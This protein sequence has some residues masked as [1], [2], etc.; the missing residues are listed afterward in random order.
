MLQRIFMYILELYHSCWVQVVLRTSAWEMPKTPWA[1]GRPWSDTQELWHHWWEGPS[2]PNVD[3]TLGVENACH[4]QRLGLTRVSLVTKPL[5]SLWTSCILR[6]CSSSRSWTNLLRCIRGQMI[7]LLV[8]CWCNMDGHC[9]W[10]HKPRWLS[11]ETP[12]SWK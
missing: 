10:E 1:Q 12:N 9:I 8:D 6:P 7:F 4:S 5:E 2:D 11:K 3:E